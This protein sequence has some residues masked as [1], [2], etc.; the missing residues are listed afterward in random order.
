MADMRG[1]L[2]SSDKSDWVTPWWV[3]RF[4]EGRYGKFS[5]DPC[6]TIRSA[7]ARKW[8]GPN[9]PHGEDGLSLPWKGNVFVNPPYG[10]GIAPWVNKA[11]AESELKRNRRVVMLLP[12]RTDTQWFIPCYAASAW[13]FFTGRIVFER[14]DGAPSISAPFPSVAVVFEGNSLLRNLEVVNYSSRELERNYKCR[15]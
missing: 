9:S 3:V 5:L 10:S 15:L 8:Y 7:K 14:E 2:G 6:A 1:A 4:F 12:V 11:A 13:I